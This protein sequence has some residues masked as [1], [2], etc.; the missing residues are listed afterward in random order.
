MNLNSGA[1]QANKTQQDLTTGGPWP[2]VSKIPAVGSI[3]RPDTPLSG[4][5]SC[6]AIQRSYLTRRLRS[7]RYRGD[8][9]GIDDRTI[10]RGELETTPGRFLGFYEA[11]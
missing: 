10:G 6:R 1:E 4:V 5:R 2:G 7:Q 8:R 3:L 11:N 9:P